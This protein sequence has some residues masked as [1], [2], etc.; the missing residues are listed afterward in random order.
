MHT[1]ILSLMIGFF[2]FNFDD[3][4]EY[5][6][7][8]DSRDKRTSAAILPFMTIFPNPG[9]SISSGERGQAAG[10]YTGGVWTSPASNNSGATW[11]DPENAYDENTATSTYENDGRLQRT[12]ELEYDAPQFLTDKWRIMAVQID[13]EAAETNPDLKVEVYRNGSY[14]TAWDGAIAK[15]VWFDYPLGFVT[16]ADLVRIT[17][18]SSYVLDTLY[19]YE[20]QMLDLTTLV[21]PPRQKVDVSLIRNPLVSRG[22]V[23]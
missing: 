14:Y 4:W 22:L 3:F 16:P 11:T 5:L 13:N 19:V 6:M 20:F 7:A 23:K 1:I 21:L 2:P 8:V 10:V 12:L 15:N 9:N 18:N 17:S